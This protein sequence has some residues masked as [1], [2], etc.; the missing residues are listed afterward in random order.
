MQFY[1]ICNHTIKSNNALDPRKLDNK[2]VFLLPI[3]LKLKYEEYRHYRQLQCFLII[4][5][6]K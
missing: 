2:G 5:L 4:K 1:E 3:A 6:V